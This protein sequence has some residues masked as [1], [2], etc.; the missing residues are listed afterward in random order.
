MD[1]GAMDEQG[2]ELT[3][4]ARSRRGSKESLESCPE[5]PACAEGGEGEG[6]GGSPLHPSPLPE[7]PGGEA[8]WTTDHP[9]INARLARQVA[10]EAYHSR[11]QREQGESPPG[12]AQLRLVPPLN[13]PAAPLL[14]SDTRSQSRPMSARSMA[15]TSDYGSLAETEIRAPSSLASTSRRVHSGGGQARPSTARLSSNGRRLP[16]G[17]RIYRNGTL[18]VVGR[19]GELAKVRETSVY[20]RDDWGRIW[21]NTGQTYL[22]R[23]NVGRRNPEHR[24]SDPVA[25]HGYFNKCWGNDPYLSRAADPSDGALPP[26]GIINELAEDGHV[27]HRPVNP[28]AATEMEANKHSAAWKERRYVA[29][30][31]GRTGYGWD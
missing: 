7:S 9:L 25:R 22:D 4:E 17:T 13:L 24:K 6:G 18:N 26:G 20:D 5:L 14:G 15:S 19:E 16:T 29:M 3:K 8:G 11:S 23:W 27:Y 1:Y 12:A 31:M 2:R 10:A 28:K 30:T 21:P